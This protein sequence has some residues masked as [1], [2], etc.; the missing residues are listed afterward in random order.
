MSG[1]EGPRHVVSI[2]SSEEVAGVCAES[3][4]LA[5][6]TRDASDCSSF[7]IPALSSL[8]MSSMPALNVEQVLSDLTLDEKVKLLSGQDTWSTYPVARLNIP[9]ITVRAGSLA[10]IDL[11]TLY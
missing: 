3:S 10:P 4:S 1:L 11:R 8:T 2:S 5:D 7:P 9:S 6:T